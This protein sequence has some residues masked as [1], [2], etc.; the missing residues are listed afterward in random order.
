MKRAWS[1]KS[2]SFIP[3]LIV[4][5][6]TSSIMALRWRNSPCSLL[7]MRKP[8]DS[9]RRHLSSQVDLRNMRLACVELRKI[10][11]LIEKLGRNSPYKLNVRQKFS[12]QVSCE[13]NISMKAHSSHHTVIFPHPFKTISFPLSYP[14]PSLL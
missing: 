8:N 5:Q 14:L 6:Q 13:W 12:S 4:C 9:L 10:I 3:L 7:L 2:F 1:W 11:G